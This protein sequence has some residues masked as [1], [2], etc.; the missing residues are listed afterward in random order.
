[1][2]TG[3]IIY[4]RVL[5]TLRVLPMKW[6]DPYFASFDRLKMALP[7][8]KMAYAVGIR[9]QPLP[10]V[11]AGLLPPGYSCHGSH[12][13]KI[14][15]ARAILSRSEGIFQLTSSLIPFF[16]EGSPFRDYLNPRWRCDEYLFLRVWM[17]SQDTILSDHSHM[18]SGS[19][20]NRFYL[21]K[22]S[23]KDLAIEK[24]IKEVGFNPAY[25]N[26]SSKFWP[27]YGIY[28]TPELEKTAD[29]RD[30]RKDGS[31]FELSQLSPA[32]V[33]AWQGTR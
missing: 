22:I 11:Y 24:L 23:E 13:L 21:Q 26:Y 10:N 16:E 29:D 7:S 27:A 18:L 1:M 30:D 33:A 3:W 20:P 2:W 17:D 8:N 31:L 32:N 6:L 28:L 19:L 14:S 9:G 12:S 25:Y 15:N 5:T 4:C